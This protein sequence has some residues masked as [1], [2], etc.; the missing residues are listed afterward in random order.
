MYT[1][2]PYSTIMFYFRIRVWSEAVVHNV[3]ILRKKLMI[4]RR[5]QIDKGRLSDYRIKLNLS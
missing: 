2:W 3:A 1:M 4:R 5:S